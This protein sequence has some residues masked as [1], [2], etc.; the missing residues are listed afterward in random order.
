MRSTVGKPA[1]FLLCLSLACIV[2]PLLATK[3]EKPASTANEQKRAVHALN[4]LTF[5]P[6]PGDVEQVSAMGVDR[7]IDQQLHPEK[8]SD[9]SIETRLSALRTLHMSTKELREEFPDQQ[10]IRQVM[11]GRRS[12]PSDPP[13]RAIYEV[14]IARL[15]QKQDKRDRKEPAIAPEQAPQGPSASE[16]AK[17]AEE[18]AAAAASA[19]AAP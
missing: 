10:M 5:G 2:P 12:M 3:K 14:Q 6:R 17:T 7:W 11:D 13:R 8:I 4:R 15:R 16:S 18:L 19:D 9:D 1:A